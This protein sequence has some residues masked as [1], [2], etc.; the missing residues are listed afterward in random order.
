[1]GVP[2]DWWRL[3]LAAMVASAA[4]PIAS[5]IWRAVV[6]TPETRPECCSST[7]ETAESTLGTKVRPRPM[8]KTIIG[9]IPAVRCE[10]WG[11]RWLSISIPPDAVAVPAATSGRTPLLATSEATAA[12]VM[13]SAAMP[14]RNAPPVFS[15]RSREWQVQRAEKEEPEQRRGEQDLHDVAAGAVAVAEDPEGQERF[16]G[17]ASIAAKAASPISGTWAKP[18]SLASVV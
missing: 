8:H 5:P 13:S 18:P 10:L 12:A 9:T 14:G 2:E 3:V 15:G 4:V 17:R 16:G 7:P 6:A 11:P 1:M